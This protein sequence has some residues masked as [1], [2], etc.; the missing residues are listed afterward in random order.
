MIDAPT[1]IAC[2]VAQNIRQIKGTGTDKASNLIR[3]Y[4]ILRLVPLSIVVDDRIEW[5]FRATGGFCRVQHEQGHESTIR[6]TTYEYHNQ[7]RLR[8][9][10][11]H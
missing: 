6:S 7:R 1:M 3:Q 5:R 2:H 4:D 10:P 11:L 9:D 8:Y